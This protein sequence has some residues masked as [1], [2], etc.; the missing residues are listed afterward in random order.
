LAAENDFTGTP[1]TIGIRRKLA[2]PRLFGKPARFGK[3]GRAGRSGR[4][5][6]HDSGEQ[7]LAARLV[8]DQEQERT[9]EY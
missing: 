6:G 4:G 8:L 2:A 1:A 5:V 3:P 7:N 9:V